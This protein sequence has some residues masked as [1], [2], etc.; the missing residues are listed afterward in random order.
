M[1]EEKNDELFSYGLSDFEEVESFIAQR[2]QAD[3]TIENEEE[4]NINNGNE[5]VVDDPTKAQDDEKNKDLSP[6]NTKESSR[7]TP[8]FKLLVGEGFF[9]SSEEWDGTA[10]GLMELEYNK[11][12][13][14]K[15][16]YK[17]ETLSPRVKWLQDNLEEGVPF[18][19]LLKLDRQSV[20]YES[21]TDEQLTENVELQKLVATEYYRE[22]TK[23][24]EDRIQREIKRLEDAN[25]LETESKTFSKELNDIIAEKKQTALEN[26]KIERANNEK[27]QQKALADFKETL[28][29]TAEIIPGMKINSI[30]RDKIYATLTTPVEID[31]NGTPLNKIAKARMENPL[32]FEIKL[33]YIFE[34]TNGF[35]NWE[36]M[37]TAGRKQAYINFEQEAA[38]LDTKPSSTN[39]RQFQ[40]NN[41]FLN[42]LE[43]LHKKGLI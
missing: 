1:A 38:R 30:M 37:T 6:Q 14:W 2:Q 27:A 18:E 26:A 8:Y 22:T 36:S 33:A 20:V 28:T 15:E 39:Q 40:S 16:E 35:K 21:I 10:E 11:F 25:E 34:L 13:K 9:D 12:N 42:E 5:E 24:S 23:F 4:E 43:G 29:K 17:T 32:D 3:T 31:K 7:L 41:E 19:E